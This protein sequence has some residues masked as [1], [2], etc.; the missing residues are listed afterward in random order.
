M[1]LVDGVI[2]AYHI[3]VTRI[4]IQLIRIMIIDTADYVY[5][6]RTRKFV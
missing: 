4:I 1:L 2:I 5:F 3:Y 6:A